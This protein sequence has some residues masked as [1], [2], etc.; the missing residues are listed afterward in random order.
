MYFPVFLQNRCLVEL[1]ST[2]GLRAEVG[3]SHRGGGGA[4]VH[5]GV[6]PEKEVAGDHRE[7]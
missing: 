6:A 5:V 3:G 2:V 7:E 4:G 1:L